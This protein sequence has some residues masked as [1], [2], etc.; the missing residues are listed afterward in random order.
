MLH[1]IS[2]KV[3]GDI[4]GEVTGAEIRV[5]KVFPTARRTLHADIRVEEIA[6]KTAAL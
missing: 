6:D 5:L 4:F 1:A 3:S 2:F